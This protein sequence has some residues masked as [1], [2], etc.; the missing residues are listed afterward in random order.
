MS[1]L[2]GNVRELTNSELSLDVS[3]VDADGV[4]I[5]DFS[6]VVTFPTPPATAAITSPSVTTTST[7]VLA[8]NAARRQ[9]IIH[10]DSASKVF[11]AFAATATTTAFTFELGGNSTFVSEMSSYTGIITGIKSTGSSTLRVTEITV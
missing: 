4:Q 11:I 1:L 9:C 10:N 5:T 6:P 3:I 8:A 2:S 7:T